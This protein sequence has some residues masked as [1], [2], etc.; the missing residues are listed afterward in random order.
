MNKAVEILF[1]KAKNAEKQGN[2]VGAAN[3]YRQILGTFPGNAR[4]QKALARIIAQQQQQQQQQACDP[5]PDTA[6]ISAGLKLAPSPEAIVGELAGLLHAGDT[7]TVIERAKALI[8]QHPDHFEAHFHLGTALLQQGDA[9][10]ALKVFRKAATIAPHY[11]GTYMN[12]A[13]ALR[14]L[15]RP[16]EAIAALRQAIA[17]KPDFVEVLFNLANMLRRQG[18]LDEAIGNYRAAIAIRPDF[19]Q[20]YYNLG[21]ACRDANRLAEAVDAYRQTVLLAPDF[22][23]GYQSLGNGLQ[24]LGY[25]EEA[26]AALR[27][28]VSLRPDA[29]STL[30]C[31]SSA[32][33]QSGHLEEAIAGFRKV[34]E[35]EPGRAEIYNNFG[36]ALLEAGHTAEASAA[37]ETVR[38]HWPDNA[39]GQFNSGVVKMLQGDFENGLPLYEW[40]RSKTNP[41]SIRDF[42]MPLWL[43]QEPLSGKSILVHCEQGLGDT[44][45]FMRYALLLHER[46]ARVTVSVQD[47]LLPLLRGFHPDIAVIDGTISGRFD[48]HVPMLSLPLAMGTRLDTIPA[49]TPYLQADP[50]RM[51]TWRQRIGSQGFR[52]GICWHG[53][54][55]LQNPRRAFGIDELAGLGRLP[56]ARLIS[57]HK[58]Q[59]LTQLSDLPA[60][61]KVEWLGSG[62][63]EPGADGTGGPFIDTAAVMTLCDLVVTLDTSVAHLAGALGV[64]VW[65]A[66][67][68]TPDWRW[69]LHRDD[70]PW[71]PSMRLFRQDSPGDW[72]SVFARMEAAAAPL[73]AR[74]HSDRQPA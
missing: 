26:V 5:L 25:L 28:A 2:P 34:L 66:L 23:E 59:G 62:F 18:N 32:L 7:A 11:A 65:V 35:K 3:I 6:P 68:H 36:T 60:G 67:K 22:G 42:D 13:N 20:A 16:E 70:S 19:M 47:A 37:Y 56:G 72:R 55:T 57:L 30:F 12:I 73:V 31:L 58:G 15:G 33:G 10:N 44:I 48:Y 71:N 21:N 41:V 4:A 9:Q 74:R 29:A 17:I 1:L 43:G 39:D 8:T 46:G 54:L 69:L 14:E 52:I 53:N 64:P 51:E 27:K 40:R 38:A 24:E 50:A 49:A 61:M 45:Q 63:D